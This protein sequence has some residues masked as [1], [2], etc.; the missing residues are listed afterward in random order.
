[1]AL[2]LEYLN[3]RRVLVI[4]EI[5]YNKKL[6]EKETDFLKGA[7]HELDQ[8]LLLPQTARSRFELGEKTGLREVAAQVKPAVKSN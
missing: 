2:V 1:M 5:L 4:Q 7:L 3:F 8:I 6:T